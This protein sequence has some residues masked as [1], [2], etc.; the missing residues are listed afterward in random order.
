[1]QVKDDK[2]LSKKYNDYVKK[3][4]K[5]TSLPKNM[6]HAFLTGGIICTIGQIIMNILSDYGVEKEHAN[7]VTI[8]ILIAASA[9][10]TGMNIY[11]KIGKY[12]GAGSLVPITGFANSIAC[13][14]TEYK[15]EG[16]VMG[17]GCKIFT[18]AGPVILYGLISSSV[19]GI[20]Y[21]LL[22]GINLWG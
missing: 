20:L 3:V 13:S 4:T 1:M 18:I 10:L 8:L 7:S 6:F 14:A 5:T 12:G 19:L 11:A 15:A 17:L 9:Y 21:Y 2:E 16:M 22:G